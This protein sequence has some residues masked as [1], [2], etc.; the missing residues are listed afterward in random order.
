MTVSLLLLMIYPPV[1]PTIPWRWV[2]L[3]LHPELSIA[4]IIDGH[5][6]WNSNRLLSFI[7]CWPKQTSIYRFR[8]QQTNGGFHLC[9][10][11]VYGEMA[12]AA[13]IY[14]ENGTIC[15]DIYIVPLYKYTENGNY[16]YML[17]F[18]TENKK[19]KPRRLSLIRL[20]FARRANGSL[21]FVRLLMK[22][23]TKILNRTKQ[24]GPS[25]TFTLSSFTPP[26]W[27]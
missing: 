2:H 27:S 10:S 11:V 16:I 24:T 18:Q 6:C 12:A 26:S 14:T 19:K 15:I 21:S 9:F 25:M 22:K 17:P 7:F 1:T 4:F 23:Q 20:L 5:V 3:Y 13:Y 8:L